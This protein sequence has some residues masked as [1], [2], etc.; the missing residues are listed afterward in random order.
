MTTRLAEEKNRVQSYLHETTAPVLYNLVEKIL[1]E[2]Q[3]EWFY[4]E[5]KTY[6]RDENI[7]G[8][9]ELMIT[10]LSFLFRIALRL[11]YG[12]VSRLSNKMAPIAS[13]FG[14]HVEEVAMDAMTSVVDTAFEVISKKPWSVHHRSFSFDLQNAKIYVNT[15]LEV[16]NRFSN[17]L[18]K[19]FSSDS[20]F[21]VAMDRVK[22]QI[23]SVVTLST[24]RTSSR[25]SNSSI[26][27]PWHNARAIR[28]NRPSYWRC[29][30]IERC[31]EGL[32][33]LHANLM[34]NIDST[35]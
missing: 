20:L 24:A 12:L 31:A 17:I 22:F 5:S 35:L 18:V 1:I 11:V 4:R 13:D 29:T 14:R 25:S 27:M 26:A 16:Y 6:I 30:V 3:L 28:K 34:E 10:T 33:S 9:K 21:L 23:L 8:E 7:E 2:D 19:A 15:I 32:C